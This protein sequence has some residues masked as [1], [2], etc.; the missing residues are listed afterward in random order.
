MIHNVII[1]FNKR[2]AVMKTLIIVRHGNYGDDDHL[3]NDGRNQIQ[4]LGKKLCSI[5]NQ[6]SVLLLTSPKDRARESAE[7]IGSILKTDIEAHKILWS[8]CSR[9][10]NLPGVLE[11]VKSHQNQAEVTIL[12]THYEYAELFPA[13]YARN[14]LGFTLTSKPLNKGEA[15]V[16]NCQQKTVQHVY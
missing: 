13:Y 9:P 12:V 1:F 3:N 11:L 5:I 6:S 8:D 16:I 15:L 7:I 14:E 4:E 2:G 10:E